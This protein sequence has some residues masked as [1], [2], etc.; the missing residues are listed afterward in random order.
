MSTGS[1]FFTGERGGPTGR[2]RST[3]WATAGRRSA[4]GRRRRDVG[5]RSRCTQLRRPPRET[6]AP[7]RVAPAADSRRCARAPRAGAGARRRATVGGWR[8]SGGSGPGRSRP[9]WPPGTRRC[10]GAATCGSSRSRRPT[11]TGRRRASTAT[12]AWR[13]RLPPTCRRGWT[14]AGRRRT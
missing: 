2:V 6:R 1:Q 14:G 11:T 7:A 10:A 4:A 3:V 8:A 13:P 5:G 9:S 12:A